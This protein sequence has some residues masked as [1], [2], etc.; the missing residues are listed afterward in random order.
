M[1]FVRNRVSVPELILV[2]FIL[3]V[4]LSIGGLPQFRDVIDLLRSTIQRCL[5]STEKQAHS[6]WM[7]DICHGKKIDVKNLLS[8]LMQQ[9]TCE[10]DNIFKGNNG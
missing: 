8:T 5:Q 3:E 4:A 7:R 10:W 9:C 6:A 1:K 2:P